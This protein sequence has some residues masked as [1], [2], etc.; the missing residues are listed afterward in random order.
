[1]IVMPLCWSLGALTFFFDVYRIP[2]LLV[3]AVAGLLTAQ[4]RLSDH[5]YS[6]QALRAPQPAPLPGA[7][8]TASKTDRVIVV[9][10][11][12]GG[13][14]AAAW[15]ARVL[16]GLE[17]DTPKFRPALRMISSVSGGSVGTA[18]YIG[19]LANETPAAGA[20]KAAAASSLDEVA[21]GL[22]WP[23]FLKNAV[24]W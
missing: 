21:W 16:T 19:H 23:D 15:A 6:L 18:M 14:Q 11:N 2:V 3:L 10:A 5:Y 12:G 24:P 22:A 9:A 13:I 1:M 20:S 4:S 7:A 8:I 17:S